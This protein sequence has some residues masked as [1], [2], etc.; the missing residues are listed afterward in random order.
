MLV[1][2][3]ESDRAD[4]TAYLE[5]E[6]AYHTFL[7]SD[8]ALYGFDHPFQTVFA[9]RT[10]GGTISGVYLRYY[11]NLILAGEAPEPEFVVRMLAGGTDT[12]M[13]PAAAVSAAARALP[14]PCVYSEKRLLALSSPCR[15]PPGP[16]D[17]RLAG[18]EDAPR[19]HAF[20]MYIPEF[21]RMY[22]S[23]EMISN[24]IRSGEGLHLFL[25]REGRIAAHVNSAAR[26]AG[27]CMLGG[28][29]VA[30]PYRGQGLAADLLAAL[31]RRELLAGRRPAVFSDL[32]PG[33]SLFGKLGFEEIGGW[34]VLTIQNGQQLET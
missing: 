19:I 27:A 13:G 16:P 21:R 5:R 29:A 25:E 34:G 26:T 22:A 15:L 6:A 20:L 32:P 2:C 18:A 24:R 17:V 4:L 1:S 10:P 14:I 9:R 30:A 12:V 8:I 11:N 28:L 23:E 31:C 33:R 7:L 3:T